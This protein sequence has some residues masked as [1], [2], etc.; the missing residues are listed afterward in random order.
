MMARLWPALVQQSLILEGRVAL[1]APLCSWRS[2]I[3]L[4][5]LKSADQWQG[6]GFLVFGLCFRPSGPQEV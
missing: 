5:Q 3:V 1:C 6:D 4:A 2:L